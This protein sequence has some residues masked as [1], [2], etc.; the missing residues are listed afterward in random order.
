MKQRQKK[1][2]FWYFCRFI[3]RALNLRPR[4]TYIYVLKTLFDSFKFQAASCGFWKLGVSSLNST[5]NFKEIDRNVSL[6]NVL[7]C[8]CAANRYSGVTSIFKKDFE[9]EE[10]VLRVN[11]SEITSES[12]F[13]GNLFEIEKNHE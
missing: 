13:N 6:F 5:V 11:K 1:L 2:D 4:N 7:V 9:T 3:A 10:R 8:C 12:A